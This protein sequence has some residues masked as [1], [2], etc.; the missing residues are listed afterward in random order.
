M[1]VSKPSILVVDDEE[2][3][4]TL[5]QN[6]FVRSGLSRGDGAV[7]FRSLDLFRR[8]PP[9][10]DLVLLDLTMPFMDGE[11]TFQR[12]REIRPTC[13]SCFAPVSSSKI[14]SNA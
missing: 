11:E 3:A 9:G 10:Y 8:R 7:R 2:V 12:L 5:D 13:Q 14:V 1:P 4:L 6:S